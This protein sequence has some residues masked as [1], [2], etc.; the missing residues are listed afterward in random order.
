MTVNLPQLPVT[1]GN[2]IKPGQ[3]VLV[4]LIYYVNFIVYA[5]LLSYREVKFSYLLYN[6]MYMCYIIHYVYIDL[7]LYK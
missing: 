6:C 1:D 5:A 3:S 4:L 7:G 2:S